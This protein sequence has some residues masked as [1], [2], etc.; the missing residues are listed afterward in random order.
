M[1]S[2]LIELVQR[3]GGPRAPVVGDGMLDRYI[4]GDAEG[5]SQE[6]PVI[7]LRADRRED[8]LGGA[9]SVAMM[10]RALGATV[11]VAGIVGGD[12]EGELARRLLTD[13]G[14]DAA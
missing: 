2:D 7:L 3:F 14:I 5:V 10:L 8:R 13:A 6:A 12:L 11:S 1:S 9:G 4:W